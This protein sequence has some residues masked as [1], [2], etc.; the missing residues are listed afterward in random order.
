M[1]RISFA[2]FYGSNVPISVSLISDYVAPNKR[3]FAQSFYAMGMYLGIGLSSLSEVI[4]IAVGWRNSIRWIWL[5][6][7]GFALLEIFL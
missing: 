1:A 3:G 7:T 5:V 6:C 4:D 2:V